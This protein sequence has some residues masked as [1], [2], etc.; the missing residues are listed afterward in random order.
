MGGLCGSLPK[1]GFEP[2]LQAGLPALEL[3]PWTSRVVPCRLSVVKKK[4]RARKA[5]RNGNGAP[6]RPPLLHPA[7]AEA[8]HNRFLFEF[9][10]WLGK[11]LREN[12]EVAE[13][14]NRIS[15]RIFGLLAEQLKSMRK[16]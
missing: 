13:E 3:E 10:E 11:A 8:Y 14:C 1:P 16:K 9:D 15:E 7:M 6:V 4:T 2:R 5:H 12:P